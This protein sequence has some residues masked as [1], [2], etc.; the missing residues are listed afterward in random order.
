MYYVLDGDTTSQAAHIMERD[1][2]T[3]GEREI[4]RTGVTVVELIITPDIANGQAFA[5]LAQLRVA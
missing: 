1:T 5:S 2:P 4:A 3:E